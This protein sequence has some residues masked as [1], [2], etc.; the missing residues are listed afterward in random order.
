MVRRQPIFSVV[1]RH[2]C[3][4]GRICERCEHCAIN[5]VATDAV[6]SLTYVP[7]STGAH[8]TAGDAVL[9]IRFGNW[10]GRVFRPFM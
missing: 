3:V 7:L 6:P 4:F 2:C 5:C 10:F 1:H 9:S 8:F